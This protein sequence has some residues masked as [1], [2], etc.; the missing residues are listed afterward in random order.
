M[1]T[2][3]RFIVPTAGTPFLG[4]P[5]DNHAPEPDVAALAIQGYQGTARVVTP[6]A[7]PDWTVL[8]PS[9]DSRIIYVDDTHGSSGGE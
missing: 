2:D 6:G 8:T 9:V 4:T 3:L 5:A 7:G 1:G